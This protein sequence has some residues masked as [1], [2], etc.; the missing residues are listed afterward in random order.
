MLRVDVISDIYQFSSHATMGGEDVKSSDCKSG[1][2]E[3][4]SK[5]WV[6][7]LK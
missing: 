5:S 6:E 7:K 2:S 3:V 4:C 1:I